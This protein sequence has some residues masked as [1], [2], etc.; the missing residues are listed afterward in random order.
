MTLDHETVFD[1]VVFTYNSIL[2]K[3]L[4]NVAHASIYEAK[5]DGS[6]HFVKDLPNSAMPDG[7]CS[8]KPGE[9]VRDIPELDD[10]IAKRSA[11]AP[12]LLEMELGTFLLRKHNTLP[13]LI[14]LFKEIKFLEDFDFSSVESFEEIKGLARQLIDLAYSC[15]AFLS[16]QPQAWD[17]NEFSLHSVSNSILEVIVKKFRAETYDFLELSDLERQALDSFNP[18]SQDLVFVSWEDSSGSTPMEKPVNSRATYH[19]LVDGYFTPQDFDMHME[20]I[21]KIYF[22]EALM[23]PKFITQTT[24]T[25]SMFETQQV[26]VIP[27]SLLPRLE[28]Q[29]FNPEVFFNVP[30]ISTEQSQAFKTMLKLQVDNVK[31]EMWDYCDV[32]DL[33]TFIIQ[34]IAPALRSASKLS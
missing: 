9:W 8:C 3:D 16:I 27:T 19:T 21:M 17:T 26:C 1:Q 18:A 25:S 33:E 20:K 11:W 29:G 28:D 24:L 12:C 31:D 5:T 30:D 6:I 2:N 22:L 7:V 34:I 23:L 15:S 14:D 10:F 32:P 4:T 13:G